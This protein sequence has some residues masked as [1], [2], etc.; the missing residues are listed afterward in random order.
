M[1]FEHNSSYCNNWYNQME[2]HLRFEP[3]IRL[4]K[5]LLLLS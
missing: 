4:K 3:L 1:S 2:P 5:P